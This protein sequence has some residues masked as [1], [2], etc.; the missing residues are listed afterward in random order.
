MVRIGSEILAS[1]VCEVKNMTY[2]EWIEKIEHIRMQY[3][4]GEITPR[5]FFNAVIARAIEVER[6]EEDIFDSK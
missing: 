2:I 6:T 1:V 4:E 5:E 3:M